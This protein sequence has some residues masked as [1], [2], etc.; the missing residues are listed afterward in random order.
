MKSKSNLLIMMKPL[1]VLPLQQA[2]VHTE[3]LQ[4]QQSMVGEELSEAEPRPL[5]SNKQRR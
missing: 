4:K 1:K 5:A 3:E 2:R